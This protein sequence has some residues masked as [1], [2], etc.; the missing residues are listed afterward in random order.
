[1]NIFK[2]NNKQLEILAF[3][4]EF[5]QLYLH[6]VLY[7]LLYSRCTL[8][9]NAHP[10][11]CQHTNSRQTRVGNGLSV[12]YEMIYT[13]LPFKRAIRCSQGTNIKINRIISLFCQT[14]VVEFNNT[15]SPHIHFNGSAKC[16]TVSVE[17]HLKLGDKL[18]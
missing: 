3:T 7:T 2:S 1:M 10:K 13:K 6:H 9:H 8:L 16:L 12:V 17:S 5:I 15:R 14:V 4:N 11:M 18:G